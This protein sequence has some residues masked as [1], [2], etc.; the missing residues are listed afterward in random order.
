MTAGSLEHLQPRVEFQLLER[1]AE[2]RRL[3]ATAEV[4]LAKLVQARFAVFIQPP[5][6][7]YGQKTH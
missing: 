7:D 5:A 1:R 2:L 6:G 4:A 3:Q